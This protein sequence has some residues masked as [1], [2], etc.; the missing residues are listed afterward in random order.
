MEQTNRHGLPDTI[1]RAIRKQNELYNA[2]NVH[3]SVTGL[4][5]PARI[6]QL[7]RKHFKEMSKDASEEFYALLGSG[8]HHIVELG[9]GP[10]MVVEERLFMEVDGF[11]WSGAIDVQ[12]MVEENVIDIIDYKVTSTYS[13]GNEPKAD[14]INQ[15]N[16]HS[17]LIRHNKPHLRVRG[18]YI[19]A[20]LRDWSSGMAKNDPTYPRAPIQMV[21]IPQWSVGNQMKYLRSRIEDHRK[22][23]FA[24][25]MD[26]ELE[27]C[28]EEDR[29]VRESRWA[30]VKKGGKRASKVTEDEAEARAYAAAKGKDYHVEYREGVSTR[31]GYCG[32]S[33]WCSQFAAM[34][35]GNDDERPDPLPLETSKDAGEQDPGTSTDGSVGASPNWLDAG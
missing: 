26:E 10:N 11:R 24:D 7:R 1:V 29:W 33:A 34:Q 8:V 2:G 14:W 5:Q 21:P 30:V 17:L 35:K 15:L 16:L 18:L 13:L 25:E 12:E 32:V 31:C 22:A 9:A 3:S 28:S 27:E 23:Q 6:S 4:I 19:C 20:V